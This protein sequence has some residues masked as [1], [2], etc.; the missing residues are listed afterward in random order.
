MNPTRLTVKE[1][2]EGILQ[3]NR[4]VLSKAIT[5]VESSLPSD[6]NISA[7]LIN[8]ILPYCGKSLRIGI[9]GVP[10]VGKSTFIETFGTHITT[11]GHRLA[12]L[13]VDPSSP[14]T[15]GSILGDKTR[16]DALSKNPNAFVRP[17][18]SQ[19]TLGGVSGRT[20]EAMLLCEAAG[21]DVILIETV[22]VGQSEVTVKNMVDF[23]L[24]LM[25]AGAGDELQ[26]IKKGIIEMADAIVITKADGDNI[27]KAKSAQRDFQHALHL[28][29]SRKQW[30]SEVLTCSAIEGTGIDEI[31]KLILRY[32]E[33][34]QGNG[35]FAENRR[36]QNLSWFGDSFLEIIQRTIVANENLRKEKERLELL[37]STNRLSPLNAAKQLAEAYQKQSKESPRTVPRL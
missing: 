22:G 25:L 31:W 16:M 3:N 1:Y 20:R 12:V 19:S 6:Q 18:P 21:Y 17:S 10:G 15:K 33:H 35:F 27:A 14:V 11:L 29:E 13:T 36:M 5:L 8:E 2:K 9:T 37:V 32:A 7:D 4:F 30:K 28:Y 26:G 34:M 24:L 23:F